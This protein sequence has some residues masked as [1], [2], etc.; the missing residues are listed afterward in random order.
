MHV[1]KRCPRSPRNLDNQVCSVCTLVVRRSQY[2]N[3]LKEICP[4]NIERRDY[5]PIEKVEKKE[6]ANPTI[7]E[8]FNNSHQCEFCGAT[9]KGKNYTSHLKNRCPK[10]NGSPIHIKKIQSTSHPTTEPRLKKAQTRV[11]RER[12]R[13]QTIVEL[14]RLRCRICGEV[15]DKA[16][17][18]CPSCSQHA[19][20]LE[21]SIKCELCGQ[22]LRPDIYS[23]HINETCP[24]IPVPCRYCGGNFAKSEIRI[25]VN[26]EHPEQ[27]LNVNKRQSKSN[28]STN[29]IP[30]K[31]L[32]DSAILSTQSKSRGVNKK[33]PLFEA[34][35][36]YHCGS[37][38]MPGTSACYFCG[39]K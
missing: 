39:D 15:F 32:S 30:A 22:L 19:L 37:R 16:L 12:S 6:S 29:T 25:H 10:K 5:N 13:K 18:A 7:K 1:L 8:Q 26:R 23:K 17:L 31:R 34:G 33:R 27:I 11:R 2:A 14:K 24:Q 36:C 4:G 20:A 38:V 3:H 21:T 28:T 35:I 9:L